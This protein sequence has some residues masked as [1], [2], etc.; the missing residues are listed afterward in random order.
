[1]KPE[2]NPTPEPQDENPL[3]E[4]TSGNGRAKIRVSLNAPFVLGF[5]ALGLVAMILSALT[6]GGSTRYFFELGGSFEFANP[7]FYFKLIFH[8]LGHATW[9]HYFGNFTIILL[10][11]PLLEEKYGSVLLGVAA[12][13][14]A[15]VTGLSHVLLFNSALIGASGIAFMM[16]LL[17][18]MVNVR[19]NTIPLTFIIV[20]I[21]FMGREIAASF[22]NDTISQ[23]AHIVGGLCGAAFGYWWNRK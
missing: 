21:L 13:L 3:P 2:S 12:V 23:F 17:T 5:A 4:K 8:P 15:L 9:A 7:G 6:Q 10:V 1:M 11:G 20:A 14:T 18:S 22:Q 19:Q 16:I